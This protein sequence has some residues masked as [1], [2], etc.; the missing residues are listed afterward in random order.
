MIGQKL[1]SCR[2][3]FLNP[4]WVAPHIHM[5]VDSQEWRTLPMNHY[6]SNLFSVEVPA[7]DNEVKFVFCERDKTKWINPSK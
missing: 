1:K 2:L 5:S 4:H 3:Y 6:K 7:F